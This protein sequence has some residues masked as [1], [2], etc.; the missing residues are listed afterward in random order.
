MTD[1]KEREMEAIDESGMTE[2]EV[3]REKIAYETGKLPNDSDVSEEAA[4]D[5]GVTEEE[6]EEWKQ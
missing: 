1:K 5:S 4:D 3:A 2:E 6:A